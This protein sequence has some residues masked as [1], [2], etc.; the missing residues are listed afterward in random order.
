MQFSWFVVQNKFV[1]QGF[2]LHC[3]VRLLAQMSTGIPVVFL[4]VGGGSVVKAKFQ[5]NLESNTNK[6]K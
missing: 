3:G 2:N 1:F 5:S 6:Y 4:Y